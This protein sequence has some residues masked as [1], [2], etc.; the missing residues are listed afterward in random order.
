[1]PFDFGFRKIGDDMIIK[2]A[3]GF[4]ILPAAMATLLGMNIV[5]DKQGIRG[6]F[7]SKKAWVLAML[8]TAP[9]FART[10]AAIRAAG[11]ALAALVDLLQLMLQARQAA[12][13]FLVLSLQRGDALA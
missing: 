5:L 6:R 12:P 8:L 3:G 2:L 11:R 10:L 4:E 1:M 7:G 9:V 13:Q